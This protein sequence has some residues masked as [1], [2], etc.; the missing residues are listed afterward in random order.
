MIALGMLAGLAACD[1]SRVN[2]P[3]EPA[4][5]VTSP[6]VD[7]TGEAP[8]GSM[9]PLMPGTGPT[10]FVGRWT[11][12]PVLCAQPTR[13]PRLI[14][15][16]PLRFEGEGLGCDIGRIS[17]V[18]GGYQ[19]TLSCPAAAGVHVERVQMSVTGQTLDM[20]YVDRRGADGGPRSVRLLKCTTLSDT[21]RT[22]PA[23]SPN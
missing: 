20:V 9:A 16:T 7:P 23:L 1:Q 11:P 10:S 17:Q 6:V 15:I 18:T 4:K 5:P 19:A 2:P 3:T 21:A 12:D 14:E 13:N 22:A 8:S